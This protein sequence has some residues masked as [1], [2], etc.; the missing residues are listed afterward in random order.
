MGGIKGTGSVLFN[1][2][3]KC[4]GPG[5]RGKKKMDGEK[6]DGQTL[7][8]VVKGGWVGGGEKKKNF[9]NQKVMGWKRL[10][11]ERERNN[12]EGGKER[13]LSGFP[14]LKRRGDWG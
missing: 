13:L 3:R 8:W 14:K 6:C 12:K 10:Y 11:E 2:D 9:L 5:K 4:D 1:W 7:Q